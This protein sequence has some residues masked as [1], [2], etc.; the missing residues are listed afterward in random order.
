MLTPNYPPQSSGEIVVINPANPAAGAPFTYT[1]GGEHRFKLVGFKIQLTCAIAVATRQ[2]YVYRQPDGIQTPEL[3]ANE[4]QTASST[5]GYNGI[6][7][8]GNAAPGAGLVR[9]GFHIPPDWYFAGND[10]LTIDVL[11]IQAADQLS[12]IWLELM[13]YPGGS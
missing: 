11:G 7:N 5:V 9:H 8:F 6:I 2:L 12:A 3:L 13:F 1:P 4:V 10:T